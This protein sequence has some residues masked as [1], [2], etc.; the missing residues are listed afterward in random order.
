[1]IEIVRFL[2]VVF[3]VFCIGSGVRYLLS[4]EK[5]SSDWLEKVNSEMEQKMR[6]KMGG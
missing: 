1:M 6:D 5:K 3:A 2:A 4:R